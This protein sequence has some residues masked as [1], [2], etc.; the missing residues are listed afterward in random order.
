MFGGKELS[1]N[2]EWV[3][4]SI[5]FALDGFVGAQAIKKVPTI[6]RPIAQYFIPALRNISAHHQ[7]AR[8][9]AVPLLTRREKTGE[10][11][12]DLLYWMAQEAKGDEADK[13]FIAS[14]LLKVSFA[15]IHTSAAAPSQLL[16]DLCA[17]PEYIGP[18]RR[19]VESVLNIDGTVDKRGFHKLVKLDSIMKE[20]Q[21]LNPLLL[22]SLYLRR[23]KTF[24]WLTRVS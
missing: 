5:Q 18:L 4:A 21:R 13:D 17:M 22:G 15:A 24:S 1:E 7:A 8:R 10:E 16:Y 14:I 9:A 11:A 2:D 19:E 6:L 20:S 23:C 12:L 3:Q